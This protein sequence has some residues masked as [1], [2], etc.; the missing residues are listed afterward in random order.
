MVEAYLKK[1][2]REQAEV[3]SYTRLLDSERRSSSPT[4]ILVQISSLQTDVSSTKAS[5]ASTKLWIRCIR[6]SIPVF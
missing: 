3:D 2:A 5:E 1:I 6:V 4:D